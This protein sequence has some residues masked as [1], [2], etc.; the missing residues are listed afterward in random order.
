MRK[1]AWRERLGLEKWKWI[2]ESQN[3]TP[4]S[5]LEDVAA[6]TLTAAME[7][8]FE[9]PSDSRW[10]NE[11]KKE[12]S[13]NASEARRLNDEYARSQLID[14]VSIMARIK[15]AAST[16]KCLINVDLQKID[17]SYRDRT[18]NAL[19]ASFNEKGFEV[20]RS[21]YDGDQREPEGYDNANIS[22]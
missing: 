6:R 2:F 13:M 17:R 18:F 11:I 20:R 19:K 8:G 7:A 14:E 3:R 9:A 15:A 4:E 10:P 12:G 5:E 16:G 1:D 22:W 21:K